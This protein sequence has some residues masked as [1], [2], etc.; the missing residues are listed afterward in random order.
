VVQGEDGEGGVE[1]GIRKREVLGDGLQHRR[2]SR[3][4]L[5]DHRER[6]LHGRHG[7]MGGFVGAGARPH[8]HDRAGIAESGV[9]GMRDPRVRPPRDRVGAADLVVHRESAHRSAASDQP[10]G[11]VIP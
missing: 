3:G 9:D 7:E 1:G 2:C 4:P 6:R 11:G 10:L 5:S 8:V